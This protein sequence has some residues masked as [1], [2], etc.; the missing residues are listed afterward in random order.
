MV[1]RARK[2]AYDVWL[3]AKAVDADTTV[4]VS[5][6]VGI[7]SDGLGVCL[8]AKP[9]GG[10]ATTHPTVSFVFPFVAFSRLFLIRRIH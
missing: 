4:A 2:T 5:A 8:R 3:E 6:I 10:I 7:F 9:A 1:E